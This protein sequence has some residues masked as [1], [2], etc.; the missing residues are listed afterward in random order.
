MPGVL[1]IMAFW[2]LIKTVV[3]WRETASAVIFIIIAFL[4]FLSII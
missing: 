2:K 1:L 4:L 3:S